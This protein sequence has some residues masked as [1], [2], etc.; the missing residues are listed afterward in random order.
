MCI[1]IQL[2]SS[3]SIYMHIQYVYLLHLY[4]INLDKS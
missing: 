1:L 4:K 3:S 2:Y